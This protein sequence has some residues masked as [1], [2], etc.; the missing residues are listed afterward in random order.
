M[1]DN[2]KPSSRVSICGVLWVACAA[3]LVHCPGAGFLNRH[4]GL[5]GQ[6]QVG[7]LSHCAELDCTAHIQ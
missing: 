7:C 6:C 2:V 5:F 3:A 4:P 1:V